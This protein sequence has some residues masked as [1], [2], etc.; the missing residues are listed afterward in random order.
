MYVRGNPSASS[1]PTGHEPFVTAALVATYV[2]SQL[3]DNQNFQILGQIALM[4]AFSG[5]DGGA[6]GIQSSAGFG[7]L[8]TANGV[9]AAAISSGAAAMVS[10]YV[11]TGDIGQTARAGAFAAVAA[12]VAN[13]AAHTAT[14]KALLGEGA[15]LY[16]FHA[17]SQG[18]IGALRQDSTWRW[19]GFLSGAVGAAVS[20][21][22]SQMLQSENMF[23]GAAV[24]G[25]AGGAAAEFTGG[26][27]KQGA[28]TAAIVYLFNQRGG[29][30][31]NSEK[32][33][34][35][36]IKKLL[37][38]AK[39]GHITLEEARAWYQH[40][41]GEPLTADMSKIDFG[42]I[43]ASDFPE[44]VGSFKY[45]NTFFKDTPDG[46]VYGTIKLTLTSPNTVEATAGYDNYDFDVNWKDGR[47]F[48]NI[49]T[50]AGELYNGSGS[51]FRINLH[52]VGV[53]KQ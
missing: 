19:G 44:G 20:K 12:G 2:A 16:A 26:D 17:G 22:T 35:N 9:A 47:H 34:Q 13:A 18:I 32:L 38:G 30:S 27:F 28:M 29:R 31:K 23:I 3:S 36:R 41:N 21:G 5:Y 1:D 33:R 50:K 53:L 24:S 45:I 15:G 42:S 49:F 11:A 37:N 46:N 10:T 4:I 7:S 6:L 52:G 43:S 39:D 14:G 51:P 8:F 25:F 48:R 40:G